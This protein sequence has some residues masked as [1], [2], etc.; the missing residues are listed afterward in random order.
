MKL[1]QVIEILD[2]VGEQ[3]KNRSTDLQFHRTYIPKTKDLEKAGIPLGGVIP[4][5][6]KINARPLGVPSPAWRVYLHCLNNLIV[7][8]RQ[9]LEGNQHAYIPGRGVLTAWK[10]ISSRLDS[11]EFIA[12][13]DLKAFF[14]S[15]KLSALSQDLLWNFNYPIYVV[16]LLERINRTLVKLRPEDLIPEEERDI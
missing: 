2:E 12:E 13:F 6:G 14:P 5:T 16:E 9:G 4:G 8:S 11:S 7:W 15:V 1:R 3:A 10:E